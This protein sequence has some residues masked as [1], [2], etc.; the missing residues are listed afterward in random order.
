MGLVKLVLSE[1][2][3]QAGGDAHITTDVRVRGEESPNQLRVVA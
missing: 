2:G 1:H 3:E